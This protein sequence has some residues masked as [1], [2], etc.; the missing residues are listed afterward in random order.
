MILFGRNLHHLQ[1]HQAVWERKEASHHQLC[2]TVEAAVA[3]VVEAEEEE[4]AMVEIM[5]MEI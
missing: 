2:K 4:E 1:R 3:V 5:E